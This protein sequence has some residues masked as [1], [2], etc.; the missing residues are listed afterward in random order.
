MTASMDAAIGDRVVHGL[1]LAITIRRTDSKRRARIAMISPTTLSARPN[2][3]DFAEREV[4]E[5]R[6][7]RLL[8]LDVG[9]PDHLAPLLGF[10]GDELAE[11]RRRACKR[12]AT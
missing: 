9:G 2:A 8:R 11:V 7:D 10:V 5:Y 6:P 4:M 3:R 12:F 1:V